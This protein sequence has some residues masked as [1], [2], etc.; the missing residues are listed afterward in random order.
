M[1]VRRI[2]TSLLGN[3]PHFE[4]TISTI[5]DREREL[6]GLIYPNSTA[7]YSYLTSKY[8][9]PA[10]TDLIAVSDCVSVAYCQSAFI[11]AATFLNTLEIFY[12]VKDHSAD[13]LSKRPD[14]YLGRLL[15]SF[16]DQGQ[17][18]QHFIHFL[19]PIS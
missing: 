1:F 6:P 13:F 7:Y 17:H 12:S 18:S 10:E 8:L 19:G 4:S 3:T 5:I 9:E 2:L 11:D 16:A 14:L 15:S